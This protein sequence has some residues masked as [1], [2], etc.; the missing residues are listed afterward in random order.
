MTGRVEKKTGKEGI[1]K[2]MEK[3]VN[4]VNNSAFSGFLNIFRLPFIEF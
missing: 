1:T 2:K 3:K 4:L